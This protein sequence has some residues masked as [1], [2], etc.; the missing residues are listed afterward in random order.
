MRIF[1]NQKQKDNIA[2]LCYD[3]FKILLAITVINPFLQE[4]KSSLTVI[5]IG[6]FL[7][8]VFLVWGYHIDSKEA[9][10]G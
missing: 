10:N 1:K 5:M 3:I 4:G 9:K 8:F 7:S 2:K 6:L